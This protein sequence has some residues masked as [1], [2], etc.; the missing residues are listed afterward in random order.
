MVN[1]SKDMVHKMSSDVQ[2]RGGTE[3]LNGNLLEVV[4]EV[5]Y[6]GSI[7]SETENCNKI[8]SRI[9]AVSGYSTELGRNLE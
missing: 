5:K 1:K 9:Q 8:I 3:K 2:Q 4:K 7:F 6:L